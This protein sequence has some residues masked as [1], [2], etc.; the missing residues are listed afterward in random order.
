[1]DYKKIIKNRKIRSRILKC[2]GWIP[3]SVMLRLQYRIKMDFWPDFKSPKRFTEKLQLYKMYYHN[4]IM[5]SCVD[6]YDVRNY[7]Q[8]KGLGHILNECYGVFEHP[9]DIDWDKL[10]NQFV[11]KK[12]T[13]GGGLC[14]EIVKDKLTHDKERLLQLANT[15]TLP[16]RKKVAG[17]REW[18]YSGIEKNRVIFEK[19]LVD[20]TNKDGSIE[21]YKFM[22]F[23]GKFC[24]LWVDKNRYSHHI[25]GFWDDSLL[26]L[27]NV[28]SDHETFIEPPPLPSNIGEMIKI[29]ELL[30]KDFPY[31]RIDLYNIKGDI[32]F[33]EITFYPWSGY[34]K[35]HPDSFDL[36]LGRQFD[37]S[38]IHY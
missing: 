12:T 22:C 24:Y 18:A 30:S 17:G 8:K 29:A 4:P 34:V 5:P 16:K 3:D 26:F 21:D 25:R 28:S 20:D 9:E 13:G 35:F 31:A 23:N 14:V 36:Q 2:L 1:M 19:L 10:P 7:V 27:P 32:F 37:I 38:S 15:W 33:G 6:K 11:M